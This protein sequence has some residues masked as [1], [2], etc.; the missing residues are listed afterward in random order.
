MSTGSQTQL[1]Q[2]RSQ[3]KYPRLNVVAPVTILSG[4]RF[5]IAKTENVSLG[6]M[7]VACDPSFHPAR[8]SRIRFSLPMGHLIDT[9]SELVHRRVAERLGFR[10]TSIDDESRTALAE[11][12]QSINTY[13]RRGGRFAKRF[14]VSL[15]READGPADELAETVVLSRGGGLLVC[16]GKFKLAEKFYLWWPEG[17]CGAIAKVVLRRAG[18][19]NMVELGFQFLEADNFWRMEFPPDQVS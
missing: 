5:N 7:L 1:E 15:S 13:T 4:E 16:R 6:G 18:T 12:L 2:F 19:S 9:R 14:S 11:F 17:K 3:R 8:E 10:F